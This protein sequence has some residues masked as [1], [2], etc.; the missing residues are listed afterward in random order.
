[1]KFPPAFASLLILGSLG[2]PQTVAV[3]KV[4]RPVF[5]SAQALAVSC[6]AMKDAV[7]E[8]YLLDPSK[9]YKLTTGDLAA[10]GRCT[11]YIEGV[12]DEFREPVGSHYQS[13]PAGRGELPILIDTFLKRVA[14]HPEEGDFAAST[15]LHEADNDVTPLRRL[16]FWDD[17]S[18]STVRQEFVKQIRVRT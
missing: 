4:D 11:G 16:W 14:A 12:A 17:R 6:Q 13:V 10:V 15:V 5:V 7:G 2:L 18:S 9:T 8:G 1:M 3:K